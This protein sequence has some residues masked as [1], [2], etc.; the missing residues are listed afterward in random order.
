MFMSRIRRMLHPHTQRRAAALG[1]RLRAARLRRRMSETELATRALVS[2]PTIRRLE[3]GDSTVS[4]AVLAS[5][6]DVLGLVEDLDGIAREDLLGHEIADARIP[7]PDRRVE[8]SLA[9]EL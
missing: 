4:F 2:R 5:V 1:E 9:D 8:R 6:L 3:A 7:G